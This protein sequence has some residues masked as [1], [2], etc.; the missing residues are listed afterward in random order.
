M[1]DWTLVFGIITIVIVSAVVMWIHHKAG[2][3]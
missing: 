2:D 1:I 3:F